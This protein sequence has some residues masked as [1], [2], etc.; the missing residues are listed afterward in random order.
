MSDTLL[1]EKSTS[2]NDSGKI[3][4]GSIDQVPPGEG[5]CFI[6]GD[7]QIALFRRRDGAVF[8][9]Q[10]RCPHQGG[11]LADGLIGADAVVCPLHGWQFRLGDGAGIDN[12]S[13]VQVYPVEVSG[14]CVWLRGV[15]QA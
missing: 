5:R 13:A 1:K 11:P 14:G 10:A 4:L 8:A 3:A 9:L 12:D 15:K 7:H 6:L 2:C